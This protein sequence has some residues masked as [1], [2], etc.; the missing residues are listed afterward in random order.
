LAGAVMS[1]IEE[2]EREKN[3]K[4]LIKEKS[5]N[6][7]RIYIQKKKNEIIKRKKIL[8]A[9]IE[10]E[11]RL[12]HKRVRLVE[13]YNHPANASNTRK[14]FSIILERVEKELLSNMAKRRQM[15]SEISQMEWVEYSNIKHRIKIHIDEV[16]KSPTL[17]ENYD[18][19]AKTYS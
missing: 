8:R 19:E 7:K 4:K 1:S 16:L 13:Q 18:T 11:E 6:E 3:D 15:E 2:E 17:L 12:L 9:L 10:E 14:E 5:I